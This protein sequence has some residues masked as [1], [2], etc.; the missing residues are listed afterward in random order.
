MIVVRT[1]SERWNKTL[2][3]FVPKRLADD[4]Q[5]GWRARNVARTS[6]LM[7]G[8][9]MIMGVI[10]VAQSSPVALI[11]AALA[12][13]TFLGP[14]WMRRS[15]KVL[16]AVHSSVAVVMLLGFINIILIQGPGLNLASVGIAS[17]PLGITLFGGARA[18]GTWTLINGIGLSAIGLYALI[19]PST[20]TPLEILR[21]HIVLLTIDGVLFLVGLMYERQRAAS[22]E[23]LRALEQRHRE[24]EL[25]RIQAEADAGLSK[26][27]RFASMGRVAASVAHEINNPLAYISNNLHFCRLK[28][29]GSDPE[30][31]QALDESADGANRIAGIVAELSKWARPSDEQVEI[32]PVA[33]DKPLRA[34][35]KMA[36]GHIRP[37]A[38]VV[39][40]FDQECLALGDE[41]R[42]MQ[43]FLNLLLNAAQAI[44]EGHASQHEI[45]VDVGEEDSQVMVTIT[46]SGEGIPAELL[47][48]VRKPFFTTKA[49]G[50][51][52][53]IGLALCDNI[54]K[55]LGGSLELES[56]PG[57]TVARVLL[58]SATGKVRDSAAPQSSIRPGQADGARV[59]IVDDEPL[60]A[61][62]LKRLLPEAQVVIELSG[63]G[64]LQ[65]LRDG[66]R[67]D[68]ILCDLMMPDITGIEV[69][70]CIREEFP[71]LVSRLAFTT[72]GGFTASAQAFLDS[73]DRVVLQKPVNPELLHQL[74]KTLRA[75][76]VS[77]L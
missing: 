63:A 7:S 71:Q 67:F 12:L 77:G 3:G 54:L 4:P 45:E 72:G 15:G 23:S 74:I 11:D 39:T 73:T 61:K 6:F 35:L 8:V 2:D 59:L 31:I 38:R 52:T 37:R 76:R 51:G 69:D 34:A 65:R 16:T 55:R 41:P 60:V 47:E 22:V 64:A 1:L 48:Q 57:K 26:A 24:A 21:D 62:G 10:R 30:V 25:A 17:I 19:Q 58:A 75:K 14:F 53:G 20:A 9:F 18:G 46:D 13:M 44:P 29:E 27:E 43:V 40:R 66:E 50:E 56:Q 68:L 70:R 42:L 5:W 33:V 32:E 28:L 49:P 36:E